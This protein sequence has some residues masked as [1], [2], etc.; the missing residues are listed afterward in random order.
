MF[1]EPCDISAELAKLGNPVSPLNP[2][3]HGSGNWNIRTKENT[4]SD[5]GFLV[6]SAGLGERN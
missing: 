1:S 3:E 5:F 4:N 6:C 2:K